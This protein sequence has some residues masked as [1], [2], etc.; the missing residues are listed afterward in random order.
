MTKKEEILNKASRIHELQKEK[1][2]IIKIME[3]R[4]GASGCWSTALCLYKK[5][6]GY[7]NREYEYEVTITVSDKLLEIIEK[8]LKLRLQEIELELQKFEEDL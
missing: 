5:F 4:T 8:E 6:G 2:N 7:S 3:N 1:E